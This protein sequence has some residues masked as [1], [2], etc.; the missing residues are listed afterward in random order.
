MG[1]HVEY[2]SYLV[3]AASSRRRGDIKGVRSGGGT[4][5]AAEIE[6]LHPME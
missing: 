1:G 4:I 3:D 5:V 6:H 2:F